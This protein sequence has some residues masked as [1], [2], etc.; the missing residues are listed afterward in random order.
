MIGP[1]GLFASVRHHCTKLYTTYRAR[2]TFSAAE[3]ADTRHA[4]MPIIAGMAFLAHAL[5]WALGATRRGSRRA[6][7]RDVGR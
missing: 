3:D 1:A 5:R 6:R 2:H 7:W 4:L